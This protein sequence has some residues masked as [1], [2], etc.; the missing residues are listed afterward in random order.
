MSMVLSTDYIKFI[1]IQLCVVMGV[2]VGRVGGYGRECNCDLLQ[3]GRQK[4]E[5]RVDFGHWCHCHRH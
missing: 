2:C 3:K 5:N 1:F 4:T